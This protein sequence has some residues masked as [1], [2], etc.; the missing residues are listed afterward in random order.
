MS[1][2][3]FDDATLANE[4]IKLLTQYLV[5]MLKLM[6]SIVLLR[7]WVTLGEVPWLVVLGCCV[8]WEEYVWLKETCSWIADVFFI[9]KYIWRQ[10][11]NKRKDN[12]NR[13]KDT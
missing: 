11:H 12:M 7:G 8:L 2:W 9:L 4:D 10:I 6:L 13:I 1:S 5:I 3:N